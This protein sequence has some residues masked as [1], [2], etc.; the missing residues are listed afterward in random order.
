MSY[1]SLA[2]ATPTLSPVVGFAVYVA[3]ASRHGDTLLAAKAFP[4]LALFN[5][6]SV[7]LGILIQTLP[8]VIGMFACFD[9]IGNFLQREARVDSR[10]LMDPK[11]TSLEKIPFIELRPG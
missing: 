9:R 5:L 6:L 11:S 4:A 3:V 10:C 1:I 7:P 2:F 8:E